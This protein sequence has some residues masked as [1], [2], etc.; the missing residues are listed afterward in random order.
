MDFDFL[1]LNKL[2]PSPSP[3]ELEPLPSPLPTLMSLALSTAL[4]SIKHATLDAL[5]VA[6]QK[7]AGP[8]GYAV[9]KLQSKRTKT[10]VVKTVHIG[11]NQ[12]EK[13]KAIGQKQIQGS[14]RKECLFFATGKHTDMGWILSTIW[15]GSHNHE[16]T[17]EESHASLQGFHMTEKKIKSIAQQT[18]AHYL[19]KDII[20]DLRF[21]ENSDNLIFKAW[22]I[23]NAKAR[24][25]QEALSSFSLI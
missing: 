12:G 22:D 23:Y 5:I 4:L 18:K 10:G 25:H 19:S 2:K 3:D 7:H 14:I 11:C 6:I 13:P 17:I 16:P 8:Q 15:D 20:T 9:I 1:L 24:I 21:D